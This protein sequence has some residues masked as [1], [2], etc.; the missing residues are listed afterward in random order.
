M[1]LLLILFRANFILKCIA[2]HLAFEVHGYNFGHC[3]LPNWLEKELTI[4][5]GLRAIL[6]SVLLCVTLVH[7]Q[8]LWLPSFSM[9]SFVKLEPLSR[10]NEYS[11]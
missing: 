4:N 8:R 7:T 11:K 5:R 1:L 10:I 9:L 2:F 6:F 3:G